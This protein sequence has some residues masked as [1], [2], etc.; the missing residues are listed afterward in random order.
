MQVRSIIRLDASLM[1]CCRFMDP[2][3][4]D[5]VHDYLK[6]LLETDST[7]EESVSGVLSL[8]TTLTNPDDPET[9]ASQTF[10]HA[11]LLAQ[12]KIHLTILKFLEAEV[13]NVDL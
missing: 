13:K 4:V 5:D 6:G 11:R 9:S 3:F 7:H 2:D 8:C 12:R 1:Q 10:M